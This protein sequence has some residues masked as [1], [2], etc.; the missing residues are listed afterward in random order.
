MSDTNAIAKK[1]RTV[2]RDLAKRVAGI[3]HSDET[4]ARRERWVRH[5]G[6][7]RSV[8]PVVYMN[9]QGS[10]VE[11][12]PRD[13]FQCRDDWGLRIEWGLRQW[14]YIVEHFLSDN[15]V[16]PEWT[17][18]KVVHNSGWGLEPRR[19]PSGQSRGAFAFDPVVTGPADLKKLRCPEVTYDEA[20]T[21]R[22]YEK[23][24]DLLGDILDVRVK[25]TWQQ[26]HLMNT[27]TALR[28]YDQVLTDMYE[29]PGML[30]EAMA[31]LAEGHHHIRKQ[32]AEQGLFGLNN[33]NSPIYT[34]GHGYT[35]EL[36][37]PGADPGRPEPMDL[38]GWAEAQEMAVVSPAQHEE[39]VFQYER[40]L[41]EPYG[42]TGY[43]C[44]E[45]LTRKLDFVLT[46]PRLRRVSISPW[47]D[48]DACAAKLGPAGVIFMW[49]PQPAHLV[50]TFDDNKVRTYI[51]KGVQAA[52]EHGCVLELALLDTHTCENHPERFDQW[53]RIVREEVEQW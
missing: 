47:S 18:H 40:P 21:Q 32:Y 6:M 20:T 19:K 36:P 26:F 34:S 45:D 49:K 12:I 8:R 2:L 48:V 30:H 13:T 7:D 4:T 50:G 17:V 22:E 9:P 29:N 11:L 1:D 14:I 27:W 42:L 43:G 51:R 23:V 33:D 39:F 52:K 37:R 3:G 16:E 53:S 5:T 15:V 28:G 24:C 31:F 44:C 41:L 46:I 35:D 38:W 10:W 25:G